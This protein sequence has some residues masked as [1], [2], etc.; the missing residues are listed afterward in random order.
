MYTSQM[1]SV[2]PY[3]DGAAPGLTSLTLFMSYLVPTHGL[4]E[5]L[6]TSAIS[7]F[8]ALGGLWTSVDGIFAILFG[9]NVVYFLFGSRHL[10]ALG[11]AHIFQRGTLIR[12]WHED[13]PK[14][15]TEG[16]QPGSKDAGVVAF[17]RQRLLDVGPDPKDDDDNDDKISRPLSEMEMTKM[18]DDE[19]EDQERLLGMPQHLRRVST[20]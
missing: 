20:V 19:S 9:A 13:F 17:I 5:M 12:R 8:S 14:L 4:Q 6:G 7:G 18:V 15:H 11:M 10:S 16:G 2:Q 1:S 3:P